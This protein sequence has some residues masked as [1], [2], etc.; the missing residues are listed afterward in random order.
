MEKDCIQDLMVRKKKENGA[1]EKDL[2][3]FDYLYNNKFI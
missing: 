3:G 2:N 1:K